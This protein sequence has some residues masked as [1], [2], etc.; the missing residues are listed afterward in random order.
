MIDRKVFKWS[1]KL[2]VTLTQEWSDAFEGV[3]LTRRWIRPISSAIAKGET[4][5]YRNMVR[6]SGFNH[7]WPLPLLPPLPVAAPTT[8]GS[9]RASTL[10]DGWMGRIDLKITRELKI[11]LCT[12]NIFSVYAVFVE[13]VCARVPLHFIKTQR[14]SEKISVHTYSR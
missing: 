7:C 13:S 9:A 12:L 11:N 1:L 3:S 6:S 8:G 10:N 14:V 5:W 2:L 4:V